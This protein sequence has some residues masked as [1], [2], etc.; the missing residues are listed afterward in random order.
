MWDAEAARHI[1]S[2]LMVAGKMIA[3]AS[4]A[5]PRHPTRPGQVWPRPVAKARPI[6]KNAALSQNGSSV[7]SLEEESGASS[8]RS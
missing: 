6:L 2:G 5:G 8:H 4:S 7:R 1:I 3:A